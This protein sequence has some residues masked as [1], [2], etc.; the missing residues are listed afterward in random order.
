[1]CPYIVILLDLGNFAISFLALVTAEFV[2]SIGDKSNEDESCPVGS[3]NTPH[4]NHSVDKLYWLLCDNNTSQSSIRGIKL[5][6]VN[7]NFC[8]P[9]WCES[10]SGRLRQPP[11]PE[12]GCSGVPR[13]PQL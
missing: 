7:K 12:S 9:M 4:Y 3:A 2:S 6:L 10:F 11:V 8:A 1:M 5:S 13:T